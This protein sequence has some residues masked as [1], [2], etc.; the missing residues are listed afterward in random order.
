[1]SLP[2]SFSRAGGAAALIL[3]LASTLVLTLLAIGPGVRPSSTQQQDLA[4]VAAVNR[5]RVVAISLDGLNSRAIVQ[6]GAKRV[7]HL[8]QLFRQGA[9]TTNAR[10]QV[11][12]TLT[13]PNHTS[14]VTGRRIAAASGG[15]GVTWN[16]HRAGSTV[17][18]AA[19]SRVASVFSVVR[20]GGGKTSLF[21]TK[22]KLTLFSRSWPIDKTV[23]RSG[24]DALLTRLFRLDILR[25]T[26]AFGFLHLGLADQ[27]GH[28]SGWM[29]SAYLKAVIK[30][31]ALV[32]SVMATIRDTARLRRSTVVVLTSDHGG[33]P[34]SRSHD[35]A[36]ALDNHRVPFV[37]W[38]PGVDQ[39]SLYAMNRDRRDPRTS[40]PAYAGVQPVRNGDLANLAT[41]V[42]GLGPVPGSLWN[43]DQRL[44]WRR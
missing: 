18:G 26:R 14:M 11:E 15:H 16:H 33:I 38:G 32:G 17:H 10:S 43:A 21:S 7:P 37:V 36:A 1:M 40:R 39:G 27:V 44:D 35:N 9:G 6:L 41:R 29:G 28:S 2:T 8:Y 19:G 30:L 12:M 23:I 22:S 24:N 42:L 4:P 25:N 31:D 13:L 20:A 34:G 5:L 3:A